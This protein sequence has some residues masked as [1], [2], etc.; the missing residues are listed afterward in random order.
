MS[1]GSFP[2]LK[3]VSPNVLLSG[4]PD[5]SHLPSEDQDRVHNFMYLETPEDVEEFKIWI[6]TLPDPSGVLM[7]SFRL[8]CF[9]IWR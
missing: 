8:F 6:R 5:L 2:P 7:R 4:F 3:F 1:N 9:F